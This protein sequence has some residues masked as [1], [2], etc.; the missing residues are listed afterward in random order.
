MDTFDERRARQKAGAVT[1]WLAERLWMEDIGSGD[2]L[3]L[4]KFFTM[5]YYTSDRGGHHEIST[6]QEFAA[7]RLA[8]AALRNTGQEKVLNRL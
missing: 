2:G 4:V 8:S 3:K 7:E 6:G 1:T 5:G